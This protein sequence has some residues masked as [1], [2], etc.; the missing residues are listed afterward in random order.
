MK[1]HFI[2]IGGIGV[3]ALARYY[4]IKGHEISGSDLDLSEITEDL[5]KMGAE[6]FIGHKAK[7]VAEDVNLIIYSLA[8]SLT[9]PE[10]KIAKKREIKC[11][12]YPQALGRLTKEYFTI[13]VCGAHGKG[14]TT[15]MISLILIKAGLDPTVI[16]GTRLTEFGDSNC[17]VGE[18]SARSLY[19]NQ[20]TEKY[21]V[22]EADEYRRVFLNY[23]PR[24]IVLTN[25][26]KEHLDCYK[27]L[28][29][30]IEAFKEF[31]SHLPE[32]GILIANKDNK[33]I[34]KLLALNININFS[35]IVKKLIYYSLQQPEV[36]EVKK[37]LKIPGKHNV[38]NALAALSVARALKIPDE[39][40]FQ[41]L[42]EYQGAWRRFEIKQ[43][44]V[45]N[46][47]V[48]VIS[49]YAHHPTEVKATLEATREKFPN[50][51]IWAI[52][53][54]HQYQRTYYLFDEF[55]KAFEL[56]DE[57]ILTKIYEVQGRE[58]KDI[59]EMISSKVLAQAIKE[60]GKKVHFIKDFQ[61]IPQFLEKKVVSGDVI[62]I[63]GA[64]TIY[65]IVDYFTCPGEKF[66][67]GV[68]KENT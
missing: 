28:D 27:N 48:T 34:K 55:K 29:E 60:R 24:I 56:A 54:P 37:I 23:W 31:I 18:S 2:G 7:N 25:I 36:D 1:I 63:M 5:K 12:T 38:S 57:I 19:A 68:F 41:A 42:S 64:G 11:Q 47:Q 33:P 44:I 3:S 14:T 61:T 6:I 40:A 59:S 66:R 52:F 50:K 32:N 39:I 21:F 58:R 51:K 62:L 22:I 53:Q 20:G 67:K 17:R 16:I 49:D 26:D 13:A 46:H 45:N 15:A 4:L 43:S 8:I 35:T 9:N 10:L 30:I 65:K